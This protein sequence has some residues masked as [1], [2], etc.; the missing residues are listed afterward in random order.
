MVSDLQ[1]STRI[2]GLDTIRDSGGLALS[3]RNSFLS[4]TE[5]QKARQLYDSLRQVAS[6][7]DQGESHFLNL[8]K[9]ATF[10]VSNWLSKVFW[11]LI[12]F[13]TEP[14]LSGCSAVSI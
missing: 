13:L 6:A 14:L 7:L 11:L 1:I 3:S 12:L 5:I 9:Q 4:G 2:I 8:E 10:L